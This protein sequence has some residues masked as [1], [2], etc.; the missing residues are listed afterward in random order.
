MEHKGKSLNY[1]QVSARLGEKDN[2][3]KLLIVESLK[4]LSREK[5]L[6]EVEKGKF[7]YVG[8]STNLIEGRIDISKWARGYVKHENFDEDITV[9]RKNLNKA[10]NG[11]LVLIELYKKKNQ[12]AGRVVSVLERRSEMFVG[13]ISKHNDTVFLDLDSNKHVSLFIPKGKD[14]NA[15]D[16]IKA[17][18]RITDWPDSAESPFGEIVEIL[19][20]EGEIKTELEAIHWEFNLPKEFP[21]ETLELS[22][23]L[24]F[25]LDPKEVAD[26]KDFRPIT[27]FTIDPDDA[28][29]FDDA[30]SFKKI[31]NL[32]EIGI[33]IA[34]VS[35]YVKEGDALDREALNRGSSVYLVD[36]VIPMLPEK[37]SNDLCSLRPNEDKYTYTVSVQMND[38]AEV[39]DHWIGK[40]LIH[41]DRRFTYGEAQEII[42]GKSGDFQE[43]IRTLDKLSKILKE[44]RLNSGALAFGGTEFKFKLDEDKQPI[45]I[46]EKSMGSANHLIEEFMLL[47]NRIV[48]EEIG[49]K[50]KEKKP[51]VYRI[52]DKPDPDKLSELQKFVSFL[53]YDLK[54]TVENASRDLNR[55]L[56][57]SSGKAEE[58]I[59]TQ[60]AIRTMSKAEYSVDNIGHYG[61]AFEH[62]SHFTSPIRRYPDLLAHRLMKEYFQEKTLLNEEEIERRNKH[63]SL[64]EKRAA[65]AER[66]SIKY[67]QAVYMSRFIGRSFEGRISGLTKWGVYVKMSNLCEG[68]VSFSSMK[69]DQYYFDEDSYMVIGKR[70]KETIRMGDEVKVFVA[71]CDVLKRHVDFRIY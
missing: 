56:E 13:V 32:Y 35:H 26:R 62:Y 7:S 43:E 64:M 54:T 11:D 4:E 22:N 1:K 42:D 5:K 36:Q 58:G 31:E 44:R 34:D 53:G 38:K 33:H 45:E 17:V 55:L 39:K 67:M 41:S 68:M 59:I 46:F 66:A 15:E 63:C 51:F 25:K 65:E 16:G 20:E 69:D 24:T 2:S 29:D 71:D 21:K 3:V 8:K 14:L 30:L 18:G 12:W 9:S 48:A 70:Y 27:T 61:L 10:L 52:H 50:P 19:G 49:K 57:Q 60:M 40:T 23:Q 28:R 47:A 6:K 37:L